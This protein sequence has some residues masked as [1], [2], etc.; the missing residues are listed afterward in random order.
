[1]QETRKVLER[2]EEESVDGIVEVKALVLEA[3]RR[4]CSRQKRHFG[5]PRTLPRTKR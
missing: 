4:W 5:A 1:M 2:R 3:K